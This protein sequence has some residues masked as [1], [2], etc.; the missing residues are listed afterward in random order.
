MCGRPGFAV[1]AIIRIGAPGLAVFIPTNP[2]GRLFDF[3]AFLPAK[4]DNENLLARLGVGC[5]QLKPCLFNRVRHTHLRLLV[6]VAP[7]PV[8]LPPL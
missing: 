6:R 8:P 4:V 2:G 3:A 5:P 7:K 1:P